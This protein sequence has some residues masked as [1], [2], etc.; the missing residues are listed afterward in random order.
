MKTV[1]TGDNIA[2]ELRKSTERMNAEEAKERAKTAKARKAKYTLELAKAETSL[3]RWLTKLFRASNQVATLRA[4][5][6]RYK[7]V[8]QA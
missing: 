7:K 5:I 8:I 4:Q 2:D 1:I 6:K 3:D